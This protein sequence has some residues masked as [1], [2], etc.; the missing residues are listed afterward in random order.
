M[1]QEFTQNHL[2]QAQALDTQGKYA[3]A[4]R[5]CDLALQQSPDDAVPHNFR[6]LLLESLS[7]EEEALQ[8]YQRAVELNPD[9]QD[10]KEN[11]RSL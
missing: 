4:L 8:A 7:R 5:E 9:F 11:V 10:A 2:E 3:D 1:T 6:G